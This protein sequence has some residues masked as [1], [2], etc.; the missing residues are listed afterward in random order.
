MEK[1]SR[2]MNGWAVFFGCAATEGEVILMEG[3][4]ARG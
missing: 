4:H 3:I 1:H 2:L